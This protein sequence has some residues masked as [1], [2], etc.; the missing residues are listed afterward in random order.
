VQ[1]GVVKHRREFGGVVRG[2][3]LQ[4]EPLRTPSLVKIDHGVV[5]APSA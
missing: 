5:T 4:I 3:R 2:K 1:S